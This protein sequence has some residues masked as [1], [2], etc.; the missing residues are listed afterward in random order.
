MIALFHYIRLALHNL[1]RGGQRI[2]VALLCI[3]F[4]VMA[5]VAMSM[6][7]KSIESAVVLTPAQR[8]GGDLSIGRQAEDF[9]RP[10]DVDQLKTLQQNGEISA[11]TLIAFNNWSL[12]LRAAGS[13]EMHFVGTA[14]GI[15]PDRYPL[16][17]SLTI[18]EPGNTGLTTLLQQVGDVIVTRDA[19]GDYGLKVGDPIV[20]SD[21]RTGIPVAGTVRGIAYD[22]PNHQGD[23]IYYSVETAQKL[24]NGQPVVNT[25]MVNTAQPQRV[26]TALESSGWGVNWPAGQGDKDTSNVWTIGLRGAGILGLLVGGIGIAN[27]MQVLLRRR[28]KEIAIW[29]TLGYQASDLRL[30][31]ALEAGILGLAG[32]LLGTGVG[33]LISSGLLELFRNTSTMLYQWTFSSTPPLMGIL[34]GTLS[35]V[36]FA[37]WAIVISSQARPL[38]LLRNEP[39]AVRGGLAWGQTVALGLLLAALFTALTSLAMGSVLAG[40]G[41]LAGIAVGMA[42]LGG[43]FSGVLWLFTRILPLRGFPLAQ[44][45]FKSLRRRGFAL[46]FA[47]IALFIGVVSMSLG[48]AVTQV[49]QRKIS[50]GAV[51]IQGSNLEILAA[52]GKESAIRQVLQAQVPEKVSLGYHTALAS[53]SLPGGEPIGPMN[54]VL[55][56]RSDPQDYLLSGADWGSQP[57]GVYASTGAD[58]KPGSQVVA[59]FRDGTTHTFSVVGS[60][61]INYRGAALSPSTG[62][63]MTTEA[64]M[65]VAQAD[66][67][68]FFVQ[69]PPGQ[70]R[71]AAADLTAA[72]PQ[73]TVVDLVAYAARFMQSYQKLYILAIAMSGLA[74]LAGILL[75]ANSVSLAVLD[76]RYE[77]GILK[78]VGYTRR[79]ILMIFAVE[80]GWVGLLATGTGVLLIQGLLALLALA[81]HLPAFAVMLDLPSLTVVA[82]CGIGLTLLTVLGVT[83]NPTQLSPVFILNDRN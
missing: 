77:I 52:G 33:V 34:V 26:V 29:K 78:T 10:A 14:M 57:D 55:L 42:L 68:T 9:L 21:L 73:D 24:A 19:A 49:S 44:I 1:R 13:S 81:N 82:F 75:V 80:Y 4:G 5:L 7:A 3:A 63:L 32:S 46:V 51:E 8:L 48:L 35:T 70:V 83:W 31:F 69:V 62:L 43:F 58:L 71:R 20:L 28:R 15:E 38:A 74:L 54:A 22:T 64:F 39:V 12:M 25:A 2:L 61:D 18:G 45:A 50:S 76:R 53:L 23:K 40:I 30:M 72:L 17:G 79:Q 47:M 11:Y 59:V 16:A 6:L 67:V 37:Y 41:V 56:G 36:I 27:T 65:R 66:S 60:Y